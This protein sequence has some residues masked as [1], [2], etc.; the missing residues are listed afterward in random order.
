MLIKIDRIM[1]FIDQFPEAYML[2]DGDWK[3]A[4]IRFEE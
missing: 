1:S 4:E 3:I 2:C